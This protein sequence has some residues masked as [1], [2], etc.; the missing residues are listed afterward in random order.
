M[1]RR[2]VP[3]VAA[4]ALTACGGGGATGGPGPLPGPTP[5]PAPT[6][7]PAK[8]QHVV[9]IFQENR[10]VDNLFNGFPGAD[11]VTSGQNSAGVTVALQPIDLA[12]PYDLDHSHR[13]FTTEYA[14]GAMNGFDLVGSG[15]CRSACPPKNQR[16]YG[17]VPPSQ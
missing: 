1:V 7:G 11:T 17:Y 5:T 13:G 10:T 6:R 14:A 9:I 4:L 15:T 12:T 16:A 2:F 8:I 3:L